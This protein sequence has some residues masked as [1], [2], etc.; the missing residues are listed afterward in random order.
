MK[1]YKVIFDKKEIDGIDL[2][3]DNMADAKKYVHV[4]VQDFEKYGF[5]VREV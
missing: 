1:H 4:L 2:Y 5:K 3:E